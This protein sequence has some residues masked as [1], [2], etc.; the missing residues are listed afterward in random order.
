MI[1][2]DKYDVFRTIKD[3]K[4]SLGEDYK[5]S[6]SYANCVQLIEFQFQRTIRTIY[7]NISSH[8]HHLELE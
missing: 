8:R 3:N 2:V 5:L 1:A 6:I 4:L 7:I